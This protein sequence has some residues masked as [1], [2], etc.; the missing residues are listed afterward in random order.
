MDFVLSVIYGI[1]IK[2]YDDITDTGIP[3]SPLL[4]ELLK[5]IQTVTLTLTTY[6]DFNYS[7]YFLGINILALLSDK[8]AYLDDMY[9]KSIFYLC[10]LV[11]VFS[12]KT[13]YMPNILD[14]FY[15][16]WFALMFA[17]E[18]LVIREDVSDRKF[19]LRSLGIVGTV[20][21]ICVGLYFRVS[22]SILKIVFAWLG[23]VTTSSIFQGYML[24]KNNDISTSRILHG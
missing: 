13:R 9:Y 22:S 17:I 23:Y 11:L 20:G 10:P 15:I 18:P 8:T 16:F 6:S 14:V 1:T 5:S 24:I 3:V 2:V 4:L 12:F 7:L 19:I 21:G